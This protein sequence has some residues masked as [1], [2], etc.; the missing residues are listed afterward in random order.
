MQHKI[1]LVIKKTIITNPEWKNTPKG[2]RQ[3]WKGN[4]TIGYETRN[5]EILCCLA[6]PYDKRPTTKTIPKENLQ[7]IQE[8]NLEQS[9]K[10]AYKKTIPILKR[11][12]TKTPIDELKEQYYALKL[13]FS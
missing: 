6:K 3:N 11:T 9:L 5:H 12:F 2:E 13:Y 4:L 1:Y 10:D 7:E 8:S